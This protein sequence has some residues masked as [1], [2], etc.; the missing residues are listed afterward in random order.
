MESRAREPRRLIKD[1]SHH[2]E[3]MTEVA[4]Q[5][6]L[7]LDDI[8]EMGDLSMAI[9]DAEVVLERA[10]ESQEKRKAPELER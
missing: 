6:V 9:S 2:L 5:Y 4:K 1:L 10:R 8:G 7:K 3:A